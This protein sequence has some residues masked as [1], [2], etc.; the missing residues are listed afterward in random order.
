VDIELVSE[1]PV[2]VV[3]VAELD[4]DRRRKE[5]RGSFRHFVDPYLD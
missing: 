1:F 5:P 3:K 4:E 2:V